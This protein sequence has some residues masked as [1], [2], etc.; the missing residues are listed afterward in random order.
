MYAF[1][2][3]LIDGKKEKS[4]FFNLA[5]TLSS[6][7]IVSCMYSKFMV[8]NLQGFSSTRSCTDQGAKLNVPSHASPAFILTKTDSFTNKAYIENESKH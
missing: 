5:V 2:A 8:V 3:L 4:M 6:I 1:E 7:K